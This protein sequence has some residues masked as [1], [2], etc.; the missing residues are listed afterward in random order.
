ME[1]VKDHID[2]KTELRE[3][4][5]VDKAEAVQQAFSEIA[6][7]FAAET[8]EVAE[9]A[10]DQL[11]AENLPQAQQMEFNAKFFKMYN[12]YFTNL[13]DGLPKKSAAR[14]IKRLIAYPLE[15]SDLTWTSKQ[16]EDAF[17]I[18]N[19]LLEVKYL[20]FKYVMNE[21][22][23]KEGQAKEEV[24]QLELPLDPQTNVAALAVEEN[25]EGE[26]NG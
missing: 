23:Q 8:G 13:I 20:M 22:I 14:V 1:D 16:E 10:P 5:E 12:M 9:K 15:T 18:G 21:Q 4:G 17:L 7:E 19:Q 3:L 25:K 26:A 6:A 2:G 24:K 11:K